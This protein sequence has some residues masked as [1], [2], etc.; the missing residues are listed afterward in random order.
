MDFSGKLVLVTGSSRGIGRATARAFLARGARVAI[1]GRTEQSVMAAIAELGGGEQLLA[2]PGD[3]TTAAGCEA[4]VGCAVAGLGGLDVLVN[5]AGIWEGGP[6]EESDES[7]WDRTIDINLKGTFFCTRAALPALTA[8]G[9]NIV[10][11]GSDA[12]LIGEAGMAVYCASK[13]GVVNLTRALAVELAR[14]VRVNCVCPGYVDT[15]MVRRDYIE[16]SEDPG[17][18]ERAVS[19]YAPMKRIATAAEVAE[20]IVFLASDEAG[21]ITGAALPIDGGTTAGR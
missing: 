11:L 13:G 20:A 2:A 19:D 6:M 9:G 18:A 10:N 12:G 4:V 1:N 5:S 21:F 16:A 17:A 8:R 14:R 7:L 15:D 3:V